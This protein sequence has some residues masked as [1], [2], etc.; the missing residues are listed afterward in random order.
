[1]TMAA[2]PTTNQLA[3][4]TREKL[5]PRL[6]KNIAAVRTRKIIDQA[7]TMRSACGS[8]ERKAAM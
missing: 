5:S 1:M 4:H 2:R 7:P 8:G 3:S 6:A